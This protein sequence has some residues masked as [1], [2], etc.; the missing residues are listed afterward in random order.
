MDSTIKKH[1]SEIRNLTEKMAIEN[2]SKQET[3]KSNERKIR[4]LQE[5]EKRALSEL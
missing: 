5:S 3:I 1:Q 2:Q 4:E